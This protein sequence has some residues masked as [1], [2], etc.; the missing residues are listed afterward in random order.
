MQDFDF[1]QIES[2][3]HKKFLLRY[4]AAFSVSTTQTP[5]DNRRTFAG[6][7]LNMYERNIE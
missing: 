7:K 3:L 6:V 4:A 5:V 1:A 2:I